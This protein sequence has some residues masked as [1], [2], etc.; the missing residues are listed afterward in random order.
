MHYTMNHLF[1]N[2]F[3]YSTNQHLTGNSRQWIYLSC[4]TWLHGT[5]SSTL[6]PFRMKIEF[7]FSPTNT[8]IDELDKLDCFT[9]YP[10]FLLGRV[11]PIVAL[12]SGWVNAEDWR[13]SHCYNTALF[14]MWSQRSVDLSTF[15]NKVM[16]SEC[17][18]A[19][20]KFHRDQPQSILFMV[21]CWMVTDPEEVVGI[22]LR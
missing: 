20:K 22:L 4:I 1:I 15:L 11:S 6:P 21:I 16:V 3:A 10:Y 8:K 5:P 18:G 12:E 17:L 2:Y 9:E 14:P 19:S 13:H 7:H